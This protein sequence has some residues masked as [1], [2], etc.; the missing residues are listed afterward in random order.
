[1]A[2]VAYPAAAGALSGLD[3]EVWR[4]GEAP[5]E[6]LVGA[7]RSVQRG[8]ERWRGTMHWG[9]THRR[10]TAIARRIFLAAMDDPRNTARVPIG[11]PTFAYGVRGSVSVLAAANNGA[12]LDHWQEGYGIGC[13]VYV[14][15]LLQVLGMQGYEFRGDFANRNTETGQPQVIFTPAVNLQAGDEIQPATHLHV[16][17][18]TGAA[19][20]L[21]GVP[22]L[23]GP[24]RLDF[25]EDVVP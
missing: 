3:L 25:V 7:Y 14:P 19:L 4:P 12:T 18:R 23:W 11:E 13:L 15:R 17:K 6:N 21:P 5:Q 9:Q 1:M 22:Y 8:R 16:R 2:T 10:E 24:W 20:S